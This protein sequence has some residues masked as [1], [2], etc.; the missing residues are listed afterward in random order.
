MSQRDDLERA[1]GEIL[2]PLGVR[3]LH[4]GADRAVA[5]SPTRDAFEIRLAIPPHTVDVEMECGALTTEAFLDH[6]FKEIDIGRRKLF[7]GIIEHI[8]KH[9]RHPLDRMQSI[10]SAAKALLDALGVSLDEIRMPYGQGSKI[11]NAALDLATLLRQKPGA[12]TWA[13]NGYG[14]DP[15]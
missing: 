2:A 14:P 1:L 8:A 11:A 3:A 4:R 5:I 10:E 7:H 12:V 15:A 13:R 6:V 9:D